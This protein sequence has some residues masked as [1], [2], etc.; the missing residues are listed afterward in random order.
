M[1][2]G[3][4]KAFYIYR[5]HMVIQ[6]LLNSLNGQEAH[7]LMRVIYSIFFFFLSF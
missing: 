4:T 2:A 1:L 6:P 7:Y 3:K 5:R